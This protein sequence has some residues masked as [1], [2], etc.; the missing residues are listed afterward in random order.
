MKLVHWPWWLNCYIWYSEEWTRRGCSPPSPLLAVQNVT[1]HPSRPVY[2][3]PYC[4][5]V[6]RYWCAVLM[7]PVIGL[8]TFLKKCIGVDTISPRSPPGAGTYEWLNKFHRRQTKERTEGQRH[9]VKAP[10]LRA[11]LSNDS[12]FLLIFGATLCKRSICYGS[13]VCLSVCHT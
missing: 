7:L 4:C 2:Q 10:L 12:K 6:V 9:R 8:T 13:S 5:I 1:A 3:S 11:G